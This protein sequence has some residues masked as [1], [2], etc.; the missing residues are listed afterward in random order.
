MF[1][2]SIR[3]LSRIALGILLTSA[4]CWGDLIYS[5]TSDAEVRSDGV[6]LNAAATSILTGVIG[7]PALDRCVVIPFQLPSLGSVSNPFLTASFNSNIASITGTPPLVSLYAMARRDSGSVVAGDYYG[8]TSTADPTDATLLQK[9]FLTSASSSGINSL[10]VVGRANLASY[11]NTQY[12]G[13]AGAGKFV[14]L[15]MSSESLVTAG[16]SY[17]ITSA[18][19]GTNNITLRPQIEYSVNPGPISPPTVSVIASDSFDNYTSGTLAGKGTSGY[20]WAS[21]WVAGAAGSVTATSSASTIFNVPAGGSMVGAG[22]S[23]DIAGS[24][25]GVPATRQLTTPPTGTFYVGLLMKTWGNPNTG[26]TY[27][28]ALT[29]SA[30]DT[31]NGLN[32]GIRGLP[33][34]GGAYYFIGKGITTPSGGGDANGAWASATGSI[35]DTRYLVLKVEKTGTGNYNKV[36]GWVNP[37]TNAE[38]AFPNGQ[39]QLIQDLG[40]ASISSLNLRASGVDAGDKTTIDSLTLTKTFSDLMSP[41]GP[42]PSNAASVAMIQVET[43]ANGSGNAPVNSQL[44]DSG[45]SLTV[46][47]ISRAA[48]GSFIANVPA[49]WS[50][51][52]LTGGVLNRDLVVSAD[53]KSAVFKANGSGTARIRAVENSTTISPTGV[54]SVSPRTNA[55]ARPFIWSRMSERDAVLAK[56]RNAGWATAQ[57]AQIEDRA[58]AAVAANR[59]NYL[60]ALPISTTTG[61]PKFTQTTTAATDGTVVQRFNAGV[62]CAAMYYLTGNDAYAQCAADLLHNS[63]QGLVN[64]TATGNGWI[65]S[66]GLLGEGPAVGTQLPV[67]YDF[68]Y[69]WLQTHQ[70]YQLGT[71][72]GTNVA[73]NFTNAQTVFRKYYQLMRDNSQAGDN[74]SANMAG[75]LVHNVLALDSPTERTTSLNTYL[76]TDAPNFSSLKTMAAKYVNPNDIWPEPL[77][78][79]NDV[80]TKHSFLMTMLEHYDPTLNLYGTYPNVLKSLPRPFQLIFPNRVQ[81]HYGDFHFAD[82][83]DIPYFEYEMVYRHAIERNLPDLIA[84]YGPLIND[85]VAKFQYRRSDPA[86]PSMANALSLFWY[87]DAVPEA[88]VA[89]PIPRSD[90][91]A[92]SGLALQRNIPTNNNTSNA[93]MYFVCGGGSYTHQHAHGMNMELYGKGTVLG[94]EGGKGTYGSALHEN[95]YRV[96]AAHNTVI[97]NGATSGLGGWGGLSMNLVQVAAMEP[98]AAQTAVSPDNSFTCTTFIDNK[99]AA[100]SGTEQRTLALVR[101]SQSTGYYVDIYR[102]K[103]TVANQFHDYIYHDLGDSLDLTQ[104]DATAV[105]MTSQPARF[106]TD[107]GDSYKQPGWRYFT[108]TQASTTYDQTVR[109]RFTATINSI[110]TYMDLHMPGASGREYAKASTPAIIE[111]PAPYDTQLA[112]VLA[113]RQVGEAWNRP[114]TVVYEPH[115]GTATSGT[116]TQVTKLEQAGIVVGLKVESTVASQNIMQYI[117]SNP[118]A[119]DT[120]SDENLGIAFTGR[121]AIITDKGNGTGSL[122]VGDGSSVQYQGRKAVSRAGTNTQFNVQ[123]TTSP[124]PVITSNAVVDLPPAVTAIADQILPLNSATGVLPFSI[125]DLNSNVSTLQ[126]TVSSSNPQLVPTSAIILGGSGANRT[127]QITPSLMQ[128]GTSTITLNVS[129]GALVTSATFLVT[130][131]ESAV[132]RFA[133]LFNTDG[134]FEGWTANANTTGATVSGGALDA[135]LNGADPQFNHSTA[136]NLSGDNIPYILIRMK[137]SVG[138]TGVVYFGN[139]LTGASSANSVSFPVTASST[140]KWIAVNVGANTNWTGHTLNALRIDPP[141]TS[142]TVSIDAI[143]G[144]NGDFN[145]NQIPDA[146]EV[147][148]QLDPTSPADSQRDSDGDGINDAAEYVLGSNPVV[149]TPNL[150]NSTTSGASITLSFTATSAGGVGY[151]GLSR[152]YDVESSTNLSTWSPM[153]GYTAILG[154]NQ[155]VTINQT[156]GNTARFYRLKAR[157][158]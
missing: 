40:I 89:L 7:S 39:M 96:A 87:A 9:S 62:D 3:T 131:D 51:T 56:I 111:G 13:G 30:S 28:L 150:L 22:R 112:P 19:G 141:G 132:G 148:N 11:L 75:S 157:L 68:L 67:I 133:Y 128:T 117:L 137:S 94:A 4:S 114:F 156:I 93:L 47:A 130:V 15:R 123:F 1:P 53:R 50:L 144:S 97:V 59:D 82:G 44:L 35:T 127:L 31:S 26:D 5:T 43:A 154:T 101:T 41:S 86:N 105:P 143:I 119:T 63:I 152:T 134:N 37:T 69:D 83:Y 74:W 91:M 52:D 60:R 49:A 64:V 98:Q 42:G 70:V 106:Q 78:Y 102:S 92:Y 90:V 57:F 48:N 33:S 61:V 23:I 108:N 99:N 81:V 14:F 24:G 145:Q 29:N 80:N 10:T 36:T 116:V 115:Q 120:Y 104:A 107:I 140:Y 55:S 122:Y 18:E 125:G 124:T 58:D 25:T 153:P 151:T 95:Y 17:N 146:W 158:Q 16:N 85:A 34:G 54:L 45:E 77:S 27:S 113:I 136:L 126:V 65:L 21:G 79:S 142:G 109:G 76:T 66:D 72:G 12:A 149:R 100:A 46:Y 32:F 84:Q 110:P 73:F 20:G 71:T 135:T 88:P 129:D 121:F 118:G 147:S 103:S 6:L 138:G 155:V 8:G 139:E 38:S 2:D